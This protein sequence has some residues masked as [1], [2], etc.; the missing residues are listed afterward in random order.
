LKVIW[1]DTCR[2]GRE[3][4]ESQRQPFYL[5]S[6]SNAGP[7]TAERANRLKKK[8]YPSQ[9]PADKGRRHRGV[10]SGE[11]KKDPYTAVT[12]THRKA[13]FKSNSEGFLSR[14]LLPAARIERTK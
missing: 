3:R 1:R 11:T 8:N 7:Q 5:D 9:E 13:S 2:G 14:L 12:R 10:S 4:E 6:D